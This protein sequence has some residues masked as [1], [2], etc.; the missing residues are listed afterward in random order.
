MERWERGL[1]ASKQNFP[2]N[3]RRLAVPG[4]AA[5]E[6]GMMIRAFAILAVLAS[7]LR[8]QTS[9]PPP[10]RELRGSW[11][12]TVRNINWPSEPGLPVAKQKQQLL[13]LI[14]SAARLRLNALI[15]QVRPAGDAMYASMLEPWSPFLTGEMGRPPSP[16]WDPLEFAVTEAH[17]RGME[18]HAWFNPYRALAG[19]KHAPSADH[20]RRRHPEW[21]MKYNI[22]WWMDPGVAEVRAQAVA[23]ML[24]VTRRYDVDGIHID[25]YFYPYPITDSAKKKI[26][27]PDHAT[28]ARYKAA[29]GPLE[30][31]AWRRQNVDQTVQ[32]IY[33]GIK[34]IKRHVKFGISP[35][36]LWR[37]NHPQGTGG[38]LDPYEDLGA[39][40]KK[41]LQNGWVDYF[42]P[43]LYWTID[44]PKL[45]FI[46]YYDW[47]LEQNTQNRH[48][49]PG[50][51]TSNIGHDRVAGEILRQMS[52]LRERGLKMTPG[53]FH[54]NFGALHKD[55]GKIATYTMERAYTTHAIPPASPWLS[56]TALPAPVVTRSGD[57]VTW[58]HADERWMSQ[59][60]W[61]V[62][63]AQIG[64][65][66]VTWKSFFKDQL[67]ADWPA[68]ASAVAIRA[69]GAGWEA[70][71]AGLAAR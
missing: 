2:V 26:E 28:F 68:G 56:Q 13:A 69:A 34:G 24:D 20:I 51:N 29:G 64:G 50:M 58:R 45:G 71:E 54:W 59:T 21:T 70:G 32:T 66:W 60:R 5:N 8:S 37:P 67:E 9:V 30:L 44:R 63:Q 14:E 3:A 22:D 18:L 40:S 52:V 19:E 39:D 15:F 61:W 10:A 1:F 46:T 47:W 43:Q 6:S 65:R 12:A 41:W 16:L 4:R 36:G 23:V 7:T 55:V 42:T 27:F 62:M 17:K 25:D 38:G 53:H 49:W 11:I 35:F 31:T 33:E 48:I 57:A